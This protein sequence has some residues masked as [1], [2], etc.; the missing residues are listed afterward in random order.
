MLFIRVVLCLCVYVCVYVH[1]FA[2]M[3]LDLLSLSET[4]TG[5]Q[6][7]LIKL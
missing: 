1:A 7:N 5:S 4:Q 3:M 2:T 6:P